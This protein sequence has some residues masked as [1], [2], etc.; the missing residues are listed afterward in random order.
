MEVTA[1]KKIKI[2]DYHQFGLTIRKISRE[3][4]RI[5]HLSERNLDKQMLTLLKKIQKTDKQAFCRYTIESSKHGMGDHIHM[6]LSLTDKKHIENVM[7]RLLKYVDAKFWS[8]HKGLWFNINK[9]EGKF[10][11]IH[12]FPIYNDFGFDGYMNKTAQSKHIF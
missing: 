1:T 4:N 10:G 3:G 5:K 2:S 7:H 9:C 12:M 6:I 8:N 11:S